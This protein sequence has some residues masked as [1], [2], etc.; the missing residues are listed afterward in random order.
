MDFAV[1]E[2]MQDILGRARAFVREELFPLEQKFLLE[3]FSKIEPV[4]L[5]KREKVKKMG[6]F[7]PQIE[8]ERVNTGLVCVTA[9]RYGTSNSVRMLW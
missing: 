9:S 4:L 3:D 8:Q 2:K 5:E 1:S 6:L 7:T